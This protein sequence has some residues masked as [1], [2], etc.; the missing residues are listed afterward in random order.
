MAESS[1]DSLEALR[2]DA[3]DRLMVHTPR[4][5]GG[6]DAARARLDGL[7]EQL[8]GALRAPDPGRLPSFARRWLASERAAGR[9]HRDV[10]GAVADVG[11][12]LLELAGERHFDP[13]VTLEMV[14]LNFYTIRAVVEA[15]AA[16]LDR[17]PPG[18]LA[19]LARRPTEDEGAAL[20]ADA[21][22]ARASPPRP[23]AAARW[24]ERRGAFL[25]E[26]RRRGVADSPLCRVLS[27]DEAIE[28]VAG[29]LFE[30]LFHDLEQGR[31]LHVWTFAENLAL[32][33]LDQ[34]GGHR[35]LADLLD[36][37]RGAAEVA[38]AERAAEHTNAAAAPLAIAALRSFTIAEA[39]VGGV[40]GDRL[41]ALEL[42]GS[43]PDEPLPRDT[44]ADL[45]TTPFAGALPASPRGPELA[46]Q[47]A[48][49]T[50]RARTELGPH[51]RAARALAHA[52]DLRAE[53][54]DA[55]PATA[56]LD[57]YG[58]RVLLEDE[59][60]PLLDDLD[61]ARAAHVAAAAA[62]EEPELAAI[63]VAQVAVAH[64][65]LMHAVA[66]L[67]ADAARPSAD[68]LRAQM[69]ATAALRAQLDRGER[70]LA[71]LERELARRRPGAEG[72]P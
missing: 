21:G 36:R 45:A 2:A 59:L 27:E 8:A 70:R 7:L 48:A 58:E 62:I 46:R 53:R 68:R 15:L 6:S 22:D 33:W 72:Q 34:G 43:A 28:I 35:P 16:E 40:L 24:W 19:E 56:A 69:D 1:A 49:A 37:L 9:S 41:R 64:H 26:A 38:L 12:V 61:R 54:A 23:D 18:E 51:G 67:V 44:L 13:G 30:A 32:G 11:Q 29:N 66:S 4:I 57:L 71:R 3:L 47:L 60:R 25:A 5:D 39:A 10:L 14:T 50:D 20:V 42:A 17:Y 52:D 65:S 63:A 55:H 31:H